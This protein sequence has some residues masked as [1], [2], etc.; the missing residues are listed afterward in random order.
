MV[1]QVTAESPRQLRHEAQRLEILEAAAAAIAEHGFHG[2][3]M[4]GLASATGRGLAT[5]YNYFSGKEEVLFALQTEAFETMTTSVKAALENIAE[6]GDRLYVFVLNHLRFLAERRAVMRVLVHEASALP[7]GKRK[8]VRLLKEGYFKICRD[9]VAAILTEGCDLPEGDTRLDPVEVE[10][11]TYSVFGMLN[12]SYG[13][14]DPRHHGT[15]QDVA[16]TI[17]ALAV[18]GLA[19]HRGETS[20][21]GPSD[22]D[23]AAM[24]AAPL[25]GWSGS[26]TAP[27]NKRP[28][29]GENGST[30]VHPRKA[31]EQDTV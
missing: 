17:H 3:T 26:G 7:A 8:T 5:F 19:G 4:R 25:A 23:L 15:P 28:Q 11:V 31:F 2:M 9:I 20:T 6:P 24:D 30:R 21:K 14:Y 16:K 12:W 22:R 13:W 18:R 1:S 27:S 10:R 29:A